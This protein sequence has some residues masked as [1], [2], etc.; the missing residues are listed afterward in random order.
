MQYQQGWTTTRRPQW[1]LLTISENFCKLNDN[2]VS[3]TSRCY[4]CHA[5]T[6]MNFGIMCM[7]TVEL[8]TFT[9]IARLSLFPAAIDIGNST[10]MNSMHFQLA[11]LQ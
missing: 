1:T 8:R 9:E 5:E 6:L 11:N 3:K 4:R 10:P 2:V 7:C